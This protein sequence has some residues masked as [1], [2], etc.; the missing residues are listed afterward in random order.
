[1]AGAAVPSVPSSKAGAEPGGM[2][3]V[4]AILSTKYID[5]ISIRASEHWSPATAGR[6]AH[7]IECIGDL[8]LE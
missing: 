6:V 3:S 7:A 8:N 2:A 5:N 4:P 1:V